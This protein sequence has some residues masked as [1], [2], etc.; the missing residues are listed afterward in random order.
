[1]AWLTVTDSLWR[2][3]RRSWLVVASGIALLLLL[4]AAVLL[5][6]LPGQ[7]SG[8][9]TAAARWLAGTSADYGAL[10]ALL[11]A[12]GF[13]NV[14]HS[15][16]LQVL[17]AVL[18]LILFIYLG[19]QIAVLLRYWQLPAL[20]H[21]PGG[22]PGKPLDLPPG[23]RVLYRRRIAA[24]QPPN[25]VT[26]GLRRRLALEFDRV[27]STALTSLP[28][29]DRNE[30]PP[31]EGL[32]AP[33][34]RLL[35]ARNLRWTPVRLVLFVGLLLALSAVWLIVI[36]G[37]ELSTPILAP[38]DE[39]RSSSHAITLHYS[40]TQG[41]AGIAPQV[42]V[43]AGSATVVLPAA[44]AAGSVS[45]ID[46]RVEPGYPALYVRTASGEPALARAGQSET[47]AGLGLT[48]PSPGSEESLIL[49][50]EAIGLRIVRMGEEAAVAADAG[51]LLEV[52]Q[53]DS[54]QPARRMA[55]GAE[56]VEKIPLND[57]GLE[58][59]F[60][61]LPG[62]AVDFRYMPGLW[63]LWLALVLVLLG[64]LSF[65]FRP[66]FL[67]IQVAPWPAQRSVVVAQSD[68]SAALAVL[69]AYM[70]ENEEATP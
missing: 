26:D 18:T 14:L 67:L 62:L 68:N 37:W 47:S 60:A 31:A 16:L 30:D 63:L 17:L 53:G 49:P 65:W 10:G 28:D 57:T 58:L 6:Q 43:Q 7:V 1:M 35:A 25:E 55:I 5:P 24:P 29:D 39:F 19:D 54:S 50:N 33:E 22:E 12:L 64:A 70:V 69:A 52:Y 36:T 45:G 66:A 11:R 4:L 38:G 21:Q 51:F 56:P 34:Q 2:G 48:F 23:G 41:T 32:P 40:V 20:L 61:Q 3:L 59:E 46:V 13:F 44:A 15:P 42:R 27:D 9:A 8:D